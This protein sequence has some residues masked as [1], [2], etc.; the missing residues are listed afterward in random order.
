MPLHAVS[1]WQFP[2]VLFPVL[3]VTYYGWF[4]FRFPL[5]VDDFW[6]SRFR[7]T[8]RLQRGKTKSKVHAACPECEVL[9][10]QTYFVSSLKSSPAGTPSWLHLSARPLLPSNGSKTQMYFPVS[11]NSCALLY[12][13]KAG[14]SH[15]VSDLGTI[16]W[17]FLTIM[18]LWPNL[19][20]MRYSKFT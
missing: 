8:A 16:F 11:A 1:T 4:P 10:A 9:Q 19:C 7:N 2:F 12:T 14:S 20:Y 3:D 17:L 18:V 5:K 13:I 6:A 15:F